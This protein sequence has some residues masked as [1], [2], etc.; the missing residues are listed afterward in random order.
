LPEGFERLLLGEKER[1]KVRRK[2]K[3]ED[4]FLVLDKVVK[5]Q[6]VELNIVKLRREG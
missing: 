4:F 3:R 6:N 2:E 5:G 1:R